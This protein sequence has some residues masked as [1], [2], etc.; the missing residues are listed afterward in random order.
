[1]NV[2]RQQM[3]DING[4]QRV[5]ADRPE[6]E[7]EKNQREALKSILRIALSEL[8]QGRNPTVLAQA[9]RYALVTA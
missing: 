4:F 8:D 1:M 6:T 9:L 5:L 3:A 7:T 2:T